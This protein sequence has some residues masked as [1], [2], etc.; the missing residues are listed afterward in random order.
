MPEFC[1]EFYDNGNILRKEG[2][3]VY[4]KTILFIG[5]ENLNLSGFDNSVRETHEYCTWKFLKEEFVY[6]QKV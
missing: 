2:L 4:E 5:T 6:R 3:E 1:K